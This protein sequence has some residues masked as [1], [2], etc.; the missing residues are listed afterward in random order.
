MKLFGGSRNSKHT[1]NHVHHTQIHDPDE[2][3]GIWE[4]PSESEGMETERPESDEPESD[5]PEYGDAGGDQNE[6]YKD[7][8]GEEDYEGGL[9]TWAKIII[10]VGTVLI[11]LF[12]ALFIWI[13]TAKPPDQTQTLNPAGGDGGQTDI[14]DIN[15]TG[16]GNGTGFEGT[17]N[18]EGN[19]QLP[20]DDG[21]PNN[22]DDNKPKTGRNE[23]IYTFLVVGKDKVGSNTD[24]IMV[25]C[26]DTENH[27]LNVVS[28]PRDTYA[29]TTY[30]SHR[31]NSIYGVGG[32]DGLMDH[33]ADFMG[34]RPDFYAVVDLNA[35]IKLVDGV[36]GV[37][38]EVPRNMNYD[39]DAQNL[40]IHF[41][42]GMTHMTGQKAM[43]YCRYR[44][45]YADADIGRIDAQHDF[46]MAAAKQ[47]L[48]KK[49]S[50]PVT[51]LI[52]I[53]LN[54]VKTD[55]D[56]SSCTW[57]AGE[58]LKLD[59]KNIQF[60]TLPA[61]YNDSVHG[62]GYVTVHIDDWVQML[63]DYF[64]PFYEEITTANLDVAGRNSNGTLY[65]TSGTLK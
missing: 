43:E 54:D 62:V 57:L 22:P 15:Q 51:T 6:K 65:A 45:G 35:F 63:N 29:N 12:A 31:I 34:Y 53:V 24:V 17:D 4:D 33:I 36:D 41:T 26:L 60:F 11:I 37:D 14:T 40:H 23:N 59:A 50:I 52:N 8:F 10:V 16:E 55:L 5:E 27:T 30:R 3:R 46:L 25:A 7:D 42:K 49:D 48:A 58:L 21:D 2:T 9:P 56:L 13:K 19:T 32:A 38:Y 61:N 20:P 47:I 1:G 44:A 64:D 39:D 18:G 28:I